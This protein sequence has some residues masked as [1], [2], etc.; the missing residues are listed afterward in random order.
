MPY[1]PAQ[2]SKHNC[3]AYAEHYA[4]LQRFYGH[5]LFLSYDGCVRVMACS[6]GQKLECVKEKD[7][8]GAQREE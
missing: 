4:D 5:G 2:E 6:T 1:M 8:W 7:F 3:Y